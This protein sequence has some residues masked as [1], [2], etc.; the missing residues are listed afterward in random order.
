MSAKNYT[1]KLDSISIK[2]LNRVGGK[3]AS[4]G[5]MIAHLKN[6]EIDVPDGFATTSEAYNDFLVENKLNSRISELLQNLNIDNIQ[7]LTQTGA[8]IR[9]LILAAPFS[10]NF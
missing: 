6:L 9:D 1:L 3:N 5:E 7:Q 10:D 4:L 8:Q 2:D